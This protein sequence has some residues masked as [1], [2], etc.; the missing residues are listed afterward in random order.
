MLTSVSLETKPGEITAIVGRS[1]AGKTLTLR[2]AAGLDRPSHG[3]ILWKERAHQFVP[4][5]RLARSGLLFIPDRNFLEPTISIRTQ[6]RMFQPT[7]DD[8][9]VGDIADQLQIRQHLDASP[10]VLSDGERRCAELAVALAR[11]PATLIV[12]DPFRGID[13]IEVD[14]VAGALQKL[15]ARGTAVLMPGHTMNAIQRV[16]NRVVWI[17]AGTSQQFLQPELAWTNAALWQEL[18]GE[19]PRAARSG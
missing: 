12:D 9:S 14:L 18:L 2:I 1:G 11:S 4:L 13:P 16:A 5:Y 17:V 8:A 10:A 19:G 3:R 7:P 6:L 15:A